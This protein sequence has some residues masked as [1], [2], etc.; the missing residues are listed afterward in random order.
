MQLF[1]KDKAFEFE[2][3]RTLSYYN[4]QGAEIGEI[5]QI[6]KKTKEGDFE[7]WY[8]E[9]LS[10]AEKVHELA[11]KSLAEQHIVSAGEAFLRASNYYR[12][13]EFFLK[14]NERRRFDCYEKSVGAFKQAIALIYKKYQILN[15]PFGGH[16]LIGYLFIQEKEAPT[17]LFIGGFDSTVE[18]LYFAGG[19]AAYKRGYNVVIFDGPGQGAV[20]RKYDM[21]AI[22]DFERPVGAVLDYLTA[23]T[24]LKIENGFVGLMGMSL[25]GYYAARTAAFDRRIDA[26]VLFD[27]FTDVWESISDKKKIFKKLENR[28]YLS[29]FILRY[30]IPLMDA[31]TRWLA[32]NAF[33]VYGSDTIPELISTVKKFTIK[34]FA[35]NIKCP[36]LLLAGTNDHFSALNQIRHLESELQCPYDVYI[37]DETFGAQEH[38]QEGNHSFAHQIIFDWMDKQAKPYLK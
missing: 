1:F 7:S 28:E 37:F 24:D 8:K 19:A 23:N 35:K 14:A 17:Y 29:N 33:W 26:C 30:I 4:Y 36:M 12:N 18:E 5:A 34:D 20:L 25:G 32:Q 2:T 16:N 3:L 13:A 31:N 38:C 9:W 11:E 21:K 27:T 6:V 10:M 22:Y 15:I